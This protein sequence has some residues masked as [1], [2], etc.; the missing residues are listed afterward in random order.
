MKTLMMIGIVLTTSAFAQQDIGT[1]ITEISKA[2]VE[3]ESVL[4]KRPYKEEEHK[5]IKNYFSDL[6]SL[7]EDLSAYQK[8]RKSFNNKIRSLGIEVFCKEIILEK[9]RWNDLIKNCTRNSFF[10]CSEDVNDF[11]AIKAKMAVQLDSDLKTSFEK[12]PSC[13]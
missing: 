6:A 10:L 12:S 7:N 9:Q 8:Y 3:V 11:T 1:R 4:D 5:A 13:N 2:R